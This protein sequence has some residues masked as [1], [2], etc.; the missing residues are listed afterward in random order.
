M[1]QERQYM[2]RTL[3]GTW[4]DQF[5]K[6]WPTTAVP[7][8][9]AGGE[10]SWGPLLWSILVLAPIGFVMAIWRLSKRY[11]GY[12]EVIALVLSTLEIGFLVLAFIG[13]AI[14]PPSH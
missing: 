14:T 12:R 11:G 9:P 6:K 3:K 13:I 4:E 10:S 7:S 2:Q 8:R 1:Q 5:G